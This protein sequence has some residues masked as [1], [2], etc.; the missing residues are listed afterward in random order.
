MSK[1]IFVLIEHLRGEVAD[2][3]YMALAQANS[4][5][6]PIGGKV[7]AVLLCKEMG[8]KSAKLAADEVLVVESPALEHFTGEAYQAVFAQL[9]KERQPRLVLMGETSIGSDVAGGVAAK[10]D[11]PLISM[12]NLLTEEGGKMTAT[13]QICGGKIMAEIDVPETT[14]IVTLIPGKFAVEGGQREGAPVTKVAAPAIEAPKVIFKQYIE[15]AGEDIDISKESILIGVGRGIGNQDALEDLEELA[16]ALGG[17]LCASRPV[18]DQNW[19]PATRLVGKSG[20][21]ISAKFYLALG[22]SGAPEHTEAIT[23]CDLII[24]VNTDPKAPIFNIAKYG[25]EIDLLDLVPVLTEKIQEA[26]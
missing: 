6:K 10:L 14:A 25:V 24:A 20:K 23:G 12:C 9:I 7:V 21:R 22:I 16:E 15:P 18:V 2:I 3:S 26:R 17:A 4:I 11:L 8:N 5:A 19:L 1:D 13:C